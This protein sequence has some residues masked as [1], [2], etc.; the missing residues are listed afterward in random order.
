MPT[1]THDVPP[2]GAVQWSPL[3]FV[4]HLVTPLLV[5]QQ[6]TNS[7][8]PQVDRAA[9]FTTAPLQLGF[10]ICNAVFA[11]PV[12][13]FTPHPATGARLRRYSME[14]PREEKGAVFRNAR[15]EGAPTAGE[16]WRRA[17]GT[18][19]PPPRRRGR[20][21]VQPLLR[22]REARINEIQ[23]RNAPLGDAMQAFSPSGCVFE[24]QLGL[25]GSSAGVPPFPEQSIVLLLILHFGPLV[26]VKQQ[27]TAPLL[28]LPQAEWAAHFFTAPL[29][30]FG[31]VGF[32]PLDSE[33]AT[34]ATQLTYWP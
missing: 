10:V 6:V 32:G 31:R 29:Q 18:A 33:L 25:L 28:I 8:L 20:A 23:L 15:L 27:V 13:H 19:P 7:G 21:G 34:P 5:R 16:H 1:A 26:D 2:F 12:A 17:L 3:D 22:R 24:Q 9:H 30:F 4:E 11:A 14:T